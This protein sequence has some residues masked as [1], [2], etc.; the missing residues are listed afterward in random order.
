MILYV[1]LLLIIGAL[2]SGYFYVQR[3]KKETIKNLDVVFHKGFESA[4]EKAKADVKASS[5]EYL[6]PELEQEKIA[7]IAEEIVKHI[8]TK[9]KESSCKTGCGHHKEHLIT[10]LENKPK[11][12]KASTTKKKK[13]PKKRGSKK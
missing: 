4:M 9:E 11:K 8:E 3:L 6:R 7:E 10:S 13:T 1:V 12:K 2:I 5:E